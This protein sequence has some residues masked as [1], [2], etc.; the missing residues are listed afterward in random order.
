MYNFYKY[1]NMLKKESDFLKEL[2]KICTESSID[3]AIRVLKLSGIVVNPFNNNK[4]EKLLKNS[5][6]IISNFVKNDSDKLALEKL[7]NDKKKIEDL[8]GKVN[9]LREEKIAELLSNSKYEKNT[10]LINLELTIRS[11]N[12]WIN[13]GEVFKE[14]NTPEFPQAQIDM[15]EHILENSSN[16]FKYFDY[17]NYEQKNVSRNFNEDALKMAQ[18]HIK[19]NT[20][21]QEIDYIHDYWK[22][23]DLKIDFD[24]NE[25]L[26]VDFFHDDLDLRISISDRRYK[27]FDTS[28][29][30]N[31]QNE[32]NFQ[33][34]LTQDTLFK[35]ISRRYFESFFINPSKAYSKNISVSKWLEAY[36]LLQKECDEKIRKGYSQLSMKNTLL[37]KT[38]YD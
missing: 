21:W 14:V 1:E 31:I 22:Y 35:S 16:V 26:K 13:K 32:L 30:M 23:A 15:Y 34:Q 6:D 2:E 29:Q 24:E 38:K 37:V 8:Y 7:I 9:N 25:Q 27:N 20:Y 36:E 18:E 28:Q 12:E 33:N 10:Y 11:F 3:R 4:Y 5:Y 17:K 19:L